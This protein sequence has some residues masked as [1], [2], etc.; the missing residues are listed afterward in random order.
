MASRFAVALAFVVSATTAFAQA[1]PPIERIPFDQTTAEITWK[2]GE[3]VGGFE[4]FSGAV[5]LVL[6]DPGQGYVENVINMRSLYADGGEVAQLLKSEGFFN[7]KKF[8]QCRYKSK[9]IHAGQDAWEV[10]GNMT[11]HGVTKPVPFRAKVRIDAKRFKAE[12][13]FNLK[14]SDFGILGDDGKKLP[15]QDNVITMT[16]KIDAPR[17]APPPQQ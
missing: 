7:V 13:S 1:K 8:P 2:R 15:P 14:L 16:V 3:H 10:S 6:F 12:T 17:T 9:T 4:K 5:G 11:I